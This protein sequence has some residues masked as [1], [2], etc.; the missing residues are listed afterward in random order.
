MKEGQ[1]ATSFDLAREGHGFT[2]ARQRALQTQGPRLKFRQQA[3]IEP[4]IVRR[5]LF[6]AVRQGLAKV[7][8]PGRSIMKTTARPS[9]IQFRPGAPERQSV[10]LAEPLQS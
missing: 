4:S 6:D 9:H 5:A 7:V 1:V 10:L 3:L 8:R 2:D